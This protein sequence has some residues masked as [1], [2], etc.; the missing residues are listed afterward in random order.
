MKDY[1]PTK[2]GEKVQQRGRSRR[3]KQDSDKDWE[4]GD[5]EEPLKKMVQQRGR[6][7]SRRRV[8]VDNSGDR[9]AG[10]DIVEDQ[11]K[12]NG[13]RTE[14]ESEM[15]DRKSTPLQHLTSSATKAVLGKLSRH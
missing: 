14:P 2:T 11:D 13:T 10:Q 1:K 6:S 5:A 4:T 8:R 3:R 7:R 12:Q 15:K 9:E